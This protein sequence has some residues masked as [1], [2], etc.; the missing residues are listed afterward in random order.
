VVYKPYKPMFHSTNILIPTPRRSN[1]A[2]FEH[3]RIQDA[4]YN[5]QVAVLLRWSLSAPHAL[6]D[7]LGLEL[8]YDNCM[9]F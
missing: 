9:W 7:V 2:A 4:S 5:G 6:A 8:V 3:L 1:C